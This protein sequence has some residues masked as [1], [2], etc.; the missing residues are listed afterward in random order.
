MVG[1]QLGVTH[2]MYA[3]I[4]M[5]MSYYARLDTNYLCSVDRRVRGSPAQRPWWFIQDSVV[6]NGIYGP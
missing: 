1:L 6:S 4:I 2:Q 3:Y 5:S